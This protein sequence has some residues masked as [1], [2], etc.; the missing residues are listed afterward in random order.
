MLPEL[1]DLARIAASTLIFTLGWAVS[2]G[3]VYWD[4]SRRKLPLI[5]IYAWTGGAVLLPFIGFAV[6]LLSRFLGLLIN[7]IL[8]LLNKKRTGWVTQ[9]KGIER[10]W[11]HLPTLVASNITK[12]TLVNPGVFTELR[13]EK[14]P[15]WV[16]SICSGPESGREFTISILPVLIGRGSHAGITLVNDLGV[17]REHAIIFEKEGALVIQDLNSTHGTHVNGKQIDEKVLS[18]RDRIKIGLTVLQIRKVIE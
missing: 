18:V 8:H 10:K 2:V 11:A 9:T 1:S 3:I 6:Y 14:S 17:S 4:A 15:R 16:F 5:K 12:D 13:P 7:L